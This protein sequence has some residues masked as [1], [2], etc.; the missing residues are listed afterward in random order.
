MVKVGPTKNAKYTEQFGRILNMD[1]DVV[2]VR[3]QKAKQV[4]D[5]EKQ[6]TKEINKAGGHRFK[7]CH[8]DLNMFII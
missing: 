4:K 6:K 7:S 8:L 3:Q 2:Y 1:V 5:K